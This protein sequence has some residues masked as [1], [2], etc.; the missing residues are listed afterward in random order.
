MATVFYFR[1]P[2]SSWKRTHDQSTLAMRF[3]RMLICQNCLQHYLLDA[4]LLA[5]NPTTHYC[6]ASRSN[7]SMHFHPSLQSCVT[8]RRLECCTVWRWRK[9]IEWKIHRRFIKMFQITCRF[10]HF[11]RPKSIQRY[12]RGYRRM[13]SLAQHQCDPHWF[14]WKFKFN[15]NEKW[16]S[17]SNSI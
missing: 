9:K 7:W 1:P 17:I 3:L 10:V 8:I 12:I 11:C 13:F 2:N 16:N 6:S 15:S 14:H 5:S 4:A